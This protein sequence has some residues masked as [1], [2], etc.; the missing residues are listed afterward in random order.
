MSIFEP[1]V[2]HWKQTRQ[3]AAGYPRPFWF[4]FWGTLISSAGNSMVWPF[5]TIYMRQRL[6]IPLTTVG[7]LFSLNFVAGLVATSFAGPAIDRF[8]RKGA[9]L[10]SLAVTCGYLLA[11]TRVASLGWW[12]VLLMVNGAFGPLFNIGSNA[13]IADSVPQEQRTEAYALLRM[14]SNLGVAIGPSVGGLV[15]AVSYTLAFFIAAGATAIFGLLILL[16]VPESIPQGAQGIPSATAVGGYGPVLRDRPFLAFVAALTLVNMAYS[17]IIALLPVYAKEHYGMPESR[18]GL[19]MATN[20][21]MVVLF[22]FAVTRITRRHADLPVLA[23]GSLFYA[24]GVGSVAWGWG[25]ATFLVSMI[26]LTI[27]ELIISPTATALTARLAP[28]DMRGRYMSLYGL[29]W[30]LGY[31]IGP[32]LGGMLSDHIAPRAIWYGGLAMGLVAA[33]CFVALW[34]HRALRGPAGET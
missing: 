11:L 32:A 30:G 5:M 3:A 6:G 13:M 31:G 12:A 8:G 21:A 28:A 18:Y 9:M 34:R 15:T 2:S 33:A 14:I 7:L 25:F 24:L 26:V 17:L 1:V 16:F 10:L 4:L 27:G 29:T 19:I 22:Q 23:L 20:A